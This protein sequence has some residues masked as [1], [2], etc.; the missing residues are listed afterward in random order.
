MTKLLTFSEGVILAVSSTLVKQAFAFSSP[1]DKGIIWPAQRHCPVTVN[2]VCPRS[3][4]RY[5]LFD[6][7]HCKYV[8]PLRLSR[9]AWLVPRVSH[10]HGELRY[11]S[12]SVVPH[13]I[14]HQV[15]AGMIVS[16][17]SGDSVHST[18]DASPSHSQPLLGFLFAILAMTG[19]STLTLLMRYSS[20]GEFIR[21]YVHTTLLILL[22]V[23][24]S[25]VSLLWS[26]C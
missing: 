13:H 22:A 9:T 11:I 25:L 1:A 16:T 20:I 6:G 24:S 21:G 23:S 17:L 5:S 14:H 7:R 19:M 12:M 2:F 4:S 10:H 3:C 18:S 8:W 15:V 26:S